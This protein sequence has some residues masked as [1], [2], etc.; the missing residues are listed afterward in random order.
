MMGDAMLSDFPYLLEEC[1]HE[2]FSVIVIAFD[3]GGFECV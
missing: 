3:R 2:I 1:Q